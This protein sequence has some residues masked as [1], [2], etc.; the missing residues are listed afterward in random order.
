MSKHDDKIEIESFTSPGY[1]Q[2]VDREKYEAM[3][4]ALLLVLPDEEPGF[5]YNEMK[6]ALLPNLPERLWPSGE[7]VGWWLMAV[8]LDLEAKNVMRRIITKPLRFVKTK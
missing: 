8:H 5:T 6:A 4:E 7:K 2:N 1:K 3:R